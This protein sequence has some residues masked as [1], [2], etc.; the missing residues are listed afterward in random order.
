[1]NK[2]MNVQTLS[3]IVY[4]FEKENE[5]TE[6]T[7]E[8]MNDV[9][10]DAFDDGETAEEE[11]KIVNQVL[12][13]IGVSL[14]GNLAA[15]PSSAVKEAPVAAAKQA[16]PVAEAEDSAVSDLEARLNNLRRGG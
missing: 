5:K 16:E 12:D 8:M 11:D 4:E 6:M 10:D 14:T 1:M 3:K 2:K 13:E 7:G 15:A 9:I